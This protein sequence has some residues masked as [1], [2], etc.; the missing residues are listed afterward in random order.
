MN[1]PYRLL[2]QICGAL[3][4]INL[5]TGC[6]YITEGTKLGPITPPA[7]T[8][9]QPDIE[10]TVGDFSYTLE[11]GKMVTSNF[12]GKQLNEQILDKWKDRKYIHDYKYVE[13][14]AFTG[15]ADYDLT[16]SGSQY[17]DSSIGMQILSGL[18]LFLVPY[19]VTQS[20]DLQYTLSDVKT[21]KK[22]TSSIE[23]SNKAYAELFLIFALP[24]AVNNQQ[25]MFERMGDHLY[26]QLYQ[27]GAFQPSTGKNKNQPFKE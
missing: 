26:N 27:Q 8:S 1:I 13:S 22:Y 15:K 24:F 3:F 25:T 4:T 16:L 7:P 17:G 10:Y 23:E 5:L 18:T 21:G 14:S 2:P 11:G 9:F 12:M 20:Y 6:A 19:T